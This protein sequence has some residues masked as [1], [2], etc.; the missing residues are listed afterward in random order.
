MKSTPKFPPQPDRV[1]VEWLDPGFALEV[2][3]L[4]YHGRAMKRTVA[5]VV[6]A[7]TA[8]AGLAPFARESGQQRGRRAIWGGRADAR[9]MLFMAAPSAARWNP[10]LRLF[11]E[12]LVARGKTKKTALA[13]VA[14]KLLVAINAMLRDGRPWNP[15]LLVQPSCC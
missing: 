2:P 7:S 9:A 15:A 12:R 1:S 13:A 8:L 3:S 6:L 4:C 11:Y 5:R 10:P 14:R